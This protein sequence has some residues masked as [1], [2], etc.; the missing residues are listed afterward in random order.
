MIKVCF[1]I[2]FTLC[3]F[4]YGC[5]GTASDTTPIKYRNN[6]QVPLHI[7]KVHQE[8]LKDSI[9]HLIKE[10]S[11]AYYPKEND[12]F[13][14]IIID[15]IL[16]SPK[17]D[18]AAFFVITKNS[19]DRF[20][21]GGNKNEYH[22]NAHCFSVYLKGDSTFNDIYWIRASNISNFY[23]LEN[24]SF[25]IKEMYFKDFSKRQDVNDNSMY[26][27]NLDDIRFWDGPVWKT[28]EE[29][30]IKQKEFEEEKK[31]HPE[32]VYEPKQ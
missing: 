7:Y 27:Y 13:T 5:A 31:K 30:K 32:N 17:K 8:I 6:T 1:F 26:K 29:E 15:T 16:Y 18:K 20:L 21:S 2:A 3:N 25:R 11:L 4:C 9:K 22:Y 12:L 19:N 23:T 28:M 24:T 14:E 10:K